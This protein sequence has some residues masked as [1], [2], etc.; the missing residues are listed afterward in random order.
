MQPTTIA[1]PGDDTAELVAAARDGDA[2][3]WRRLV[4]RYDAL[5]SARVRRFR[6][7]HD[8]AE[9]VI[10]TTWLIA[11][12]HLHRLEHDD[13]LGGWLLTIATREC[14]RLIRR[15]REVCTADLSTIDRPVDN[16]AA[17]NREFARSWLS[18]TLTEV[19][20]ELP[21]AHRAL[22]RALTEA[23]DPHYADVA[24][25]LGRPIGSIGPSRARCFRRLRGMLETRE[26]SADFLD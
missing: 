18:R 23:G 25:K 22:F 26:V 6:L 9:D 16:V 24:R 10:Q 5:L 12:Q 1:P 20:G 13:K 2:A 15:R 8:D 3:A 7:D 11:L 14:L 4:E 17:A 19:V 21:P